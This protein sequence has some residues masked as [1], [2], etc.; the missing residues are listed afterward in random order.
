MPKKY[1]S[2]KTNSKKFRTSSYVVPSSHPP[3]GMQT[4]VLA[5][6]SRT[7]L[8][9][10]QNEQDVIWVKDYVGPK[11]QDYDS[12]FVKAEEGELTEVY[13]MEGSV[14]YLYKSAFRIV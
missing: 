10:V 9:L 5:L 4:T 13:G 12:F 3:V 1:P 6:D 7:D 14:P 2:Y 8:D 11:A